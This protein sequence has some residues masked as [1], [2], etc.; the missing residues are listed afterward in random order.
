MRN[1][2]IYVPILAAI[3]MGLVGLVYNSMAKDVEKNAV[4]IEEIQ[5]EKVDNKTL[6]MMIQQQKEVIQ[7]QILN[8]QI[9][10]E[11]VYK[12]LKDIKR[13]N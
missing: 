6:Q 7:I 8:Q 9:N 12:E 2:K 10:L 3:M 5:K 11:R 13:G 1:W 4:K